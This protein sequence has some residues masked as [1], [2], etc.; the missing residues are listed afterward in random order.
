MLLGGSI[1]GGHIMVAFT[2]DALY[3]SLIVFLS[4]MVPGL[5]IGWPL[6]KKIR[7]PSA[8]SSPEA[9]GE[10][11]SPVPHASAQ[12][13]LPKTDFGAIEKLLLCFFLGLF[14]VPTFLFV[15]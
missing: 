2:F 13:A 4:A 6:L 12:G 5:A 11:S 7:S 3:F 10:R 14:A 15:E 8:T 1:I 9:P